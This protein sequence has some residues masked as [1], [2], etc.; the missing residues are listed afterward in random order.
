MN[1]YTFL[2]A[3]VNAIILVWYLGDLL[4]AKK[5]VRGLMPVVASVV[6]GAIVILLLGELF[7]ETTVYFI[8]NFAALFS[9]L[10]FYY[11]KE[12]RRLFVYLVIIMVEFFYLTYIYGSVLY[13]FIQALA[14]GTAF[15]VYYRNESVLFKYQH[16]REG[17]SLETRRDIVHASLGIVVLA[18]FVFL[19]FY[20]AVYV[21]TTLILIGYVYNSLLGDRK[22][23]RLYGLLA[24]VER[25]GA[26]YGIGAL[27]LGIGVTL[28]LGF[29]HNQHFMIIGIAAL[30][31]ADPI[32]TIVGINS[33]GPKLFYNKS[34]SLFGSLSFFAV[35]AAI[36]YPFI[37]LY[38]ILFGIGL[39]FV[40]SLKLRVD[41]NVMIPVVMILL[42]IAY[43]AY[44]HI[45]PF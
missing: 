36:G 8:L 20:Y 28:L 13:P 32:A 16:Q 18:L 7:D 42:Y 26:L 25:P 1:P 30:M 14:I 34:K 5:A 6:V 43:L 35:V 27:Y 45:L 41:D 24:S 44:F 38:S 2:F 12:T 9:I 3:A 17:R 15:G 40:E 37:G 11:I 21:T 19:P 33:K 31:L 4:R 10:P 29:I 39:A 22:K 23:G